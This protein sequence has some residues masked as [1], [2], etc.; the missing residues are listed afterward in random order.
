MPI[1]VKKAWS[2]KNRLGWILAKWESKP[3][4]TKII[5]IYSKYVITDPDFD[6]KDRAEKN[7]P[8]IARKKAKRISNNNIYKLNSAIKPKNI[9]SKK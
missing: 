5:G 9:S 1:K 4:P 2:W 8:Q 3:A 7:V 6:F